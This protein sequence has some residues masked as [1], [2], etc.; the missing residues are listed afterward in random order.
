MKNIAFL[1]IIL[2]IGVAALGSV[3]VVYASSPAIA[4]FLAPTPT[5]TPSPIVPTAQ[6]TIA[7]NV[8]TVAPQVKGN[9]VFQGSSNL[10]EV[11]LTF[12][13]GPSIYTPQVLSI[14]QANSIHATFFCVGEWVSYYPNYVQ[15]EYNAGN[16]VGNHTWDHPDLTTLSTADV[17]TQISKTST[18]IQQTIGVQPTLFRP[19]YGSINASVK[20]Q[21]A[22]MN[23]TPVLWDIDTLDWKQPGSDAIVN[24]VVGQAGDGDIILMHDGGGDRSQTV[25]ALPRIIQGLRAH[26]LQMVTVPQLIHDMNAAGTTATTTTTGTTGVVSTNT[27]QADVSIVDTTFDRDRPL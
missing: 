12:D 3:V 1:L 22:Q 7:D 2:I 23:L 14:L 6:P 25:A 4:S 16:V 15:Q 26:G 24:A 10:P 11:A 19:P 17:Q 13:D 9:V 18:L 21:I 8:A 5:P 20:G 27:P